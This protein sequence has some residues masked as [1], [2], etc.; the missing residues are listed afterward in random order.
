MVYLQ[1]ADG[2]LM[3]VPFGEAIGR[4]YGVVVGDWDGDGRLE[5]ATANSDGLNCLYAWSRD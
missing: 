3:G 2:T 4:T 1:R 5:I